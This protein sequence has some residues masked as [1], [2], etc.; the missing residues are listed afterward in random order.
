LEH[1][2]SLVNLQLL[3]GI[4]NQ[5]K[6]GK[7]FEDWLNETFKDAQKRSD[8]MKKHFIPQRISLSLDNFEEF[9]KERRKLLVAEFTRLLTI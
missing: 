1:F 9:I 6:S 8:Y 4:P 7:P 2:N 3:E 5:E